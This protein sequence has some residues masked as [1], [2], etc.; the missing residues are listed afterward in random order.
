MIKKIPAGTR[1]YLKKRRPHKLCI[2]PDKTLMNDNLYVAYDVRINGTTVIPKGTRIV[3]DWVTESS[4]TLAAQLQ[5]SRI[6]LKGS[7]QPIMADS[8][9]IESISDYNGREVSNAG[10]LYKQNQYRSTSGIVRR[11]ANLNSSPR[12]L[13][14]NHKDT[15]YLEIFTNE[16]PVTLLEDFITQSN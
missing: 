6:Y 3:G 5:L 13:L 7:G 4:P 2:Q 1:I 11:I 12:C 14:D 16:I 15:L 9:V 10:Y 8:D